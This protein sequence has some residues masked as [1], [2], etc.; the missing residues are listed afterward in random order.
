M[1]QTQGKTIFN[2]LLGLKIRTV[3]L[4]I[5]LFLLILTGLFSLLKISQLNQSTVETSE[6]AKDF[7]SALD[8]F[9]KEY[10]FP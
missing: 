3:I 2:S 9:Q 1:M 5:F 6:L 4:I 8:A 7:Q 10:G